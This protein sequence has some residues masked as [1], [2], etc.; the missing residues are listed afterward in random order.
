MLWHCRFPSNPTRLKTTIFLFEMTTSVNRRIGFQSTEGYSAYNQSVA[1]L[2]APHDGFKDAMLNAG[3]ISD[4]VAIPD[5]QIH[6][7]RSDGDKNRD[8]WYV[9]FG[10]GGAFGNWH[11]G[12]K[13]TW[14]MGCA[15]Q[16]DRRKIQ[17]QIKAAQKARRN[18]LEHQYRRSARIAARRWQKATFATEHPYLKA[19]GVCSHGLKIED[20]NLLVPVCHKQQIW[21]LQSIYPDGRKRFLSR[22]RTGG[23]YFPIGTPGKRIWLAEGYATAATVHELTGDAVVCAFNAG[24]LT[25]VAAHIRAQFI[26]REV[27]VAADH[28][29]AGLKAAREA[30]RLHTLEG[31]KVPAEWETDWNDHHTSFGPEK[32]L[33]ALSS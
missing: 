32:T 29:E 22:G 14:F 18:D 33:E 10:D 27:W 31:L 8:S 28:D 30:M 17:M 2:Y 13:E 26:D 19:K 21:S 20:K 9:F 7:F 15:S 25:K 12:L 1:A 16:S 6:R 11:T 23:C 4:V 24:N 3:L 5:G